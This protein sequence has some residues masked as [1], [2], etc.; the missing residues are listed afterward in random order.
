MSQKFY[1]YLKDYEGK[2][3]VG[4]SG[5]SSFYYVGDTEDLRANIVDYENKLKEYAEERVK[6]AKRNLAAVARANPTPLDYV[7]KFPDGDA[8]GFLKYVNQWLNEYRTKTRTLEDAQENLKN[9]TTMLMREVVKEYDATAYD[10]GKIVLLEGS[11][12]GAYWTSDEVKDSPMA[13]KMGSGSVEE[14]QLP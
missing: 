8:Q 6:N 1:K 2:I 3:K 11:E 7:R 5:G 12:N 9:Y 13:F 10:T 4:A 14:K